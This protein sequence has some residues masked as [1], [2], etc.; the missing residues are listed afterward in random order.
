MRE[1]TDQNNYEYGQFMQCWLINLEIQLDRKKK[2]FVNYD[3]II[4]DYIKHQKTDS[5]L[6]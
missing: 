1:S 4:H 2:R 5:I 6:N 3:K